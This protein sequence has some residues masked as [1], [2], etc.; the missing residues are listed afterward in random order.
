MKKHPGSLVDLIE[1]YQS[2]ADQIDQP[3]FAWHLGCVA[4]PRAEGGSHLLVQPGG[5][6]AASEPPS[7]GRHSHHDHKGT[8]ACSQLSKGGS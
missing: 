7:L 5:D 3:F 6:W 2:Q 8:W 4:R 1:Q